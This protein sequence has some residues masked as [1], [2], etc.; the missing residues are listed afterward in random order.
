MFE[1]E[2]I[3]NDIESLR[4]EV[5]YSTIDFPVESIVSN[6]KKG[7]FFIPEESVEKSL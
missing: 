5:K 2:K 7:R 6:L 4:K 1:Q 3:I